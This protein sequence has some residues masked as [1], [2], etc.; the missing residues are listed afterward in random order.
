MKFFTMVDTA[1]DFLGH[2][3]SVEF[4]AIF[5][6]VK[7][8][9]FDSWRAETPTEVSDVEIINKKGPVV[10]VANGG[11]LILEAKFEGKKLQRGADIINGRKM[12]AG[13]K[14]L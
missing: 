7:E 11:L 12:S 13:E 5:D 10:K 8:V 3:K 6:K 1:K 4:D 9:L 2:Q 14:L